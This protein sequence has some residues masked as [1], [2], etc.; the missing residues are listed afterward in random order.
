MQMLAEEIASITASVG[1]AI[2]LKTDNQILCR[3]SVG[4]APGVGAVL[5]PDR[6]LSGECVL[7][8]KVVRCDDT[9]IDPRV[10]AQVCRELGFRSVLIA[11]ITLEDR[12]IGLVELLAVDAH[13]FNED[14]VVFLN[15]LHRML[16][17][18]QSSM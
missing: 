14:D 8:G 9:D 7:T 5:Q 13:H 6:G 11:P 10:K 16:N 2:A 4:Q 1:A 12:S 17:C 15:Q 3:A 18:W